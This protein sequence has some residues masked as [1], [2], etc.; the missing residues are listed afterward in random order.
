MFKTHTSK[1]HV[2]VIAFQTTDLWNNLAFTLISVKLSA[3]SYSVC[4]PGTGF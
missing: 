2:N 1:K 3:K 4:S